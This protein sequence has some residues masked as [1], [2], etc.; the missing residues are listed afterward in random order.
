MSYDATFVGGVLTIA[1][2]QFTPE[3]TAD[4]SKIEDAED[5]M[6]ALGFENSPTFGI[7]RKTRFHDDP[8]MTRIIHEVCLGKDRVKYVARIFT[9]P[10]GGAVGYSEQNEWVKNGSSEYMHIHLE[11]YDMIV[12]IA[13]EGAIEEWARCAMIV[14]IL[15]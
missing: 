3:R 11:A 12:F 8:T 10:V 6:N 4:L 2:T 9:V 5:V 7:G 14:T 1:A 15:P 13:Y